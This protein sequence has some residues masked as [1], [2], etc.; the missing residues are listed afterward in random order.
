MGVIAINKLKFVA[1]IE[2]MSSA[3][4]AINNSITAWLSQGEESIAFTRFAQDYLLLQQIINDYKK[5]VMKDAGT[6]G[7][8]GRGFVNIDEVLKEIWR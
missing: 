8:I 1:A 3:G 7:R 5:L 2:N 6:I 4:S